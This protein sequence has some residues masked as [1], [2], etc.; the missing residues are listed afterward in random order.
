MAC[1]MQLVW[2]ARGCEMLAHIRGGRRDQIKCFETIL[3]D[4]LNHAKA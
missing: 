4:F 3:V 1:C 2:S